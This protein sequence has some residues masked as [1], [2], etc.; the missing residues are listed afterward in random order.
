MH[1]KKLLRALAFCSMLLIFH[2]A[3]SQNKEITGRVTDPKDGT[4]VP[5]VSVVAKGGSTGT[6]TG[7][8]G[9]YRLSVEPSVTTLIF[10][11]VGFVT[12]EIIIDGRSSIDVSLAGT[13]ASLGEVIVV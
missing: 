12:Q 6:Q 8:D 5:G 3:Y 7:P 10:S 2:N 11:S 4:P 9:A 13:N 1:P